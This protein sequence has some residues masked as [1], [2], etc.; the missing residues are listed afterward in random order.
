MRERS[1]GIKAAEI[2]SHFLFRLV[3]GT[4]PMDRLLEAT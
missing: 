4:I 2:P 3:D 1:V